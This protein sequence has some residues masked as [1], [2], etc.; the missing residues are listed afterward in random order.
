MYVCGCVRLCSFTSVLAYL[1][2]FMWFTYS[3]AIYVYLFMLYCV[4][5]FMCSCVFI[6]LMLFM[7]PFMCLFA[8]VL[9]LFVLIP[10]S[11]F[12]RLGLTCLLN[13]ALISLLQNFVYLCMHWWV[14]SS[15]CVSLFL[16]FLLGCWLLMFNFLMIL[17]ICL[18]M[19]VFIVL[20]VYCWLCDV[21]GFA[22]FFLSYCCLIIPALG[23]FFVAL[24]AVLICALLLYVP[25]CSL[26][27]LY[28]V[29][30]CVYYA[31]ACLYSVV[32]CRLI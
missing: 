15:M 32:P 23:W 7:S 24:F 4:Y 10:A 2:W 30:L 14:Y 22:I 11:V 28:L 18:F 12:M 6:N 26:L 25:V 31:C 21:C 20:F 8:Y 27:C 3:C 9:C 13:P 19:C 29:R 17:H 16:C 5:V 1:C